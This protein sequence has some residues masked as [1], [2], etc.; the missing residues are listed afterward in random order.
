MEVETPELEIALDEMIR[1]SD[2]I[3][4]ETAICLPP[5]SM[6]HSIDNQPDFHSTQKAKGL[7]TV[8]MVYR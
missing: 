1:A 4:E 5:F 6:S 8:I 3:K 2:V 7:T